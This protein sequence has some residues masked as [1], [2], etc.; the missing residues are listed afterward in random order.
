MFRLQVVKLVDMF[1]EKEICK[2]EDKE[3][4]VYGLTFGI[5]LAFNIITT[6]IL[7]FIFDLITAS[8]VFLISFSFIRTYSGGYHCRNT[9][10][11]YFFSSMVVILVLFIAKFTPVE[12]ILIISIIILLIS[13]PIILK[14]AP[15]ETETKPLDEI[16]KKYFRNKVILH[17]GIEFIIIIILFLFKL[18]ILEYVVC[19]GI[20]V[21]A[22][23]VLLG[24]RY[25]RR[26]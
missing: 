22:I 13:I 1:I 18:Y 20:M 12:H 16:E 4:I 11:C 10:N 14:F 3:I 23:L 9:I 17:L 24:Y 7:G 6:I 15:V 26:F 21:S 19:L 2:N 8:L 25:I 5:E